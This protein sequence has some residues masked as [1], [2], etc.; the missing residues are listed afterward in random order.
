MKK[1]D[2]VTLPCWLDASLNY[3]VGIQRRLST[4]LCDN[5]AEVRSAVVILSF[6]L[7]FIYL[8]WLMVGVLL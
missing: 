2:F 3:W 5:Q 7:Y 1:F 6:V 8:L 4:K